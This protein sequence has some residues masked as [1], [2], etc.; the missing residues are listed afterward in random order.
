MG[1]HGANIGIGPAHRAMI[2]VQEF[3]GMNQL[4]LSMFAWVRRTPFAPIML[5]PRP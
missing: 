3:A 2:G 5:T 1:P 4:E